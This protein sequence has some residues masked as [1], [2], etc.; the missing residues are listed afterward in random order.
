M[1]IHYICVCEIDIFDNNIQ[2]K[3]HFVYINRNNIITLFV[4]TSSFKS[5]TTA[6][7]GTSTADKQKI[8]NL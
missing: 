6:D 4:I 3:I 5:T 7:G 1:H 2:G 8:F